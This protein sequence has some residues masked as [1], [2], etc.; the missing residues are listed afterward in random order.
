MRIGI[1]LCGHAPDEFIAQRGDVDA[2]FR[3]LLAERGFEFQTWPVVDMD[4]PEGPEAAD[5][6]LITGS[7]HGVYDDLPFIPPLE[8]LVRDIRAARKPLVGI[9]FGHQ[10]IAQALGGCVE[11]FDGGWQRGLQR[12]EGRGN[13]MALYAWHQDQVITPPDMARTLASNP[14]CAHAIL[15]YGPDCLTIQ[16]H[17]EFERDYIETLMEHRA[18]AATPAEIAAVAATL[19][20]PPDRAEAAAL[21]ADALI[22]GAAS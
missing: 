6:W 16:G 14:G 18:G 8:A 21:I 20:T 15:R 1:L 9:C 4:F 3:D 13:A 10:I 19:G 17:P 22:Q 5:G 11:K 7:K 2:L 12:Y